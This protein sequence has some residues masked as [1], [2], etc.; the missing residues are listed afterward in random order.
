MIQ[1]LK[2]HPNIEYILLYSACYLGYGTLNTGLGPLIPY[3]SAE[4]GIIES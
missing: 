1:Q 3:L 4:I 2:K